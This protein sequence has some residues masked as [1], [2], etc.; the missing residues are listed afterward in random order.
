[1]DHWDLPVAIMNQPVVVAN[2]VQ[3]TLS[4]S[5]FLDKCVWLHSLDGKTTTKQLFSYVN[6]VSLSLAWDINIWRPC[7]PPSNSFVLWR[8]MHNKL[9]TDENLR[10]FHGWTLVLVCV[11]C[12]LTDETS[13]RMIFMHPFTMHLWLWLG[14]KINCSIDTS[15][16]EGLLACVLTQC[17]SQA[18]GIIIS[19]IIHKVDTIWMERNILH[20]SSAKFLFKRRRQKLFPLLFELYH[21]H[22]FLIVHCLWDQFIG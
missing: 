12:M 7:I 15:S 13:P 8:L 22:K 6:H 4:V 11:L 21:F 17:S 20:F 18:R 19:T 5:S 3:L 10:I 9:P 1:M 2:I 16:F 14:G